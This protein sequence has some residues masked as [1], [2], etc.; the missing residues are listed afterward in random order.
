MIGYS[1]VS[2]NSSGRKLN[3]MNRPSYI[4]RSYED[5][6]H[7]E[8]V[9]QTSYREVGKHRGRRNVIKGPHPGFLVPLHHLKGKETMRYEK[10]PPVESLDVFK[11]ALELFNRESV[12][13]VKGEVVRQHYKGFDLNDEVTP[14]AV[15]GVHLHMCAY[16][17]ECVGKMKTTFKFCTECNGSNESPHL[18]DNYYIDLVEISRERT[19]RCSSCMLNLLKEEVHGTDDELVIKLKQLRLLQPHGVLIDPFLVSCGR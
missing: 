15:R 19:V 4:A 9:E 10:V 18:Y 7:D 2:N 16:F 17:Y 3:T 14:A 11:T 8:H 5:G 1:V 13:P 12:R 6:L